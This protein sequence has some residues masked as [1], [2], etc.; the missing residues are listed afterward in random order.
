MVMH[1]TYIGGITLNAS[2]M[3]ISGG[4][5]EQ[6]IV[7]AGFLPRHWLYEWFSQFHSCGTYSVLSQSHSIDSLH[8]I[9]LHYITLHTLRLD[10]AVWS[11]DWTFVQLL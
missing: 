7:I 9:T 1:D 11:A 10:G 8:Y 3:T 6:L 5:T 4:K 2:C